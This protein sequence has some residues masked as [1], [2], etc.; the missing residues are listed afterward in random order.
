MSGSMFEE[1][2]PLFRCFQ[3]NKQKKQQ[4]FIK[5]LFYYLNLFPHLV[6]AQNPKNSS[7]KRWPKISTTALYCFFQVFSVPSL[8]TGVLPLLV[9]SLRTGV[10]PLLVPSL[11][12]VLPL[13]VPSLRTGV[14][15]LL[16]PSLRT[17]VLPLLVPSLRTGVLPLLV[18][19]LKG[20]EFCHYLC[21]P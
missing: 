7:T 2:S 13:L 8:R 1:L 4:L 5:N 15:P 21:H 12:G 19:S 18:P 3:Y 14:L 6:T 10:L 17:G 11:T 20:L 16:V 9:P